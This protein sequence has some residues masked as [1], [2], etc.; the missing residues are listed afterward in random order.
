M[1]L[2]PFLALGIAIGYIQGGRMSALSQIS[3]RYGSLVMMALAIQLTLFVC[4]FTPYSSL[5]EGMVANIVS[6]MLVIAFL[7]LNRQ[8]KLIEVVAAGLTLNFL[9][10]VSN[11]GYMPGPTVVFASSTLE[12]AASSAQVA[13]A[14][15]S[16]WFLGDTFTLPLFSSLSYAFSIGDILI[17]L[18]MFA[19]I[20]G[21]MLEH[22]A[23]L[24]VAKERYQPKHLARPTQ[25]K[26][27]A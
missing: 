11:G 20:R 19:I 1:F 24:T 12:S 5:P 16:L 22:R 18:G 23:E 4:G 13:N 2:V 3:L 21:T 27:S 26:E 14:G 15:S 8:V 25:L 10:I 7:L 6:Y 17:A 9:A